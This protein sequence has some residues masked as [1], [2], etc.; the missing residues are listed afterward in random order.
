M[1]PV[2][3]RTMLLFPVNFLWLCETPNSQIQVLFAF[4]D[5]DQI[6]WTSEWESNLKQTTCTPLIFSRIWVK[7]TQA[8]FWGTATTAAI[9]RTLGGLPGVTHPNPNSLDM[10]KPSW[11]EIKASL[12]PAWLSPLA[13]AKSSALSSCMSLLAAGPY[14]PLNGGTGW[15]VVWWSSC[16]FSARADALTKGGCLSNRAGASMHIIEW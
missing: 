7:A 9:S 2:Y 15:L 6:W 1:N 13:P 16:H 11:M 8:S 5:T 12:I 3:L 14:F 4:S 10:V